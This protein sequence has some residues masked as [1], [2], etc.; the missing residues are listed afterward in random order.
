MLPWPTIL[1]SPSRISE[2]RNA[3]NTFLAIGTDH[4]RD[5]LYAII[6]HA[7]MM[8]SVAGV[9]ARKGAFGLPLLGE[10]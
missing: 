10:V 3:C 1:R 2:L 7:L 5:I 9:A 4:M 8:L 6:C